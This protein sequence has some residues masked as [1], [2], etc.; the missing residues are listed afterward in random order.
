MSA[1]P[2]P[3]APPSVVKRDLV[4]LAADKDAEQALGGL[5]ANRKQSL[6]VRPLEYDIVR[7]PD[8]DPGCL[9]QSGGILASYARTHNHAI[10]VFDREGCG[11]EGTSR[12]ELELEVEASLAK[13]WQSRVAV[14]VIDPELEAWVWTKPSHIPRIIGWP[15]EDQSLPDWL[16]EN[17]HLDLS[18]QVKPDRPK[19]A[20]EGVLRQVRKPRSSATFRQVAEQVSFRKCTDPAFAKLLTTLRKWFPP[21]A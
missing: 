10:V 2:K 11:R 9:R 21:A 15:A 20:F 13:A 5:L 3:K 4:L 17:G 8:H 6:Q 14:V 7:H 18:T 16:V 12:E 1:S 19:E